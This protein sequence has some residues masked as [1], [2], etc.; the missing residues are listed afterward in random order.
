[1]ASDFL[2][3]LFQ[4]I[5]NGKR[6]V[7]E[8]PPEVYSKEEAIQAFHAPMTL[9]YEGGSGHYFASARYLFDFSTNKWEKELE[10]ISDSKE[11][12]CIPEELAENFL[13]KI[14]SVCNLPNHVY[15]T[16]SKRVV[17]ASEAEQYVL[18]SNTKRLTWFRLL[19]FNKMFEW[20]AETDKEE[21]YCTLTS[22]ITELLEKLDI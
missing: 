13:E 6:P 14:W 8:I 15:S 18:Q 3:K 10:N 11:T 17:P 1:M 9:Y 7:I 21:P 16:D 22:A 4:D 12:G 20:I 5:A 2:E 19:T